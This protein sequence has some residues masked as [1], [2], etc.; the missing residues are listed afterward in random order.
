MEP[1]EVP[2]NIPAQM[3]NARQLANAEGETAHPSEPP[4]QPTEDSAL[5]R[6]WAAASKHR[7]ERGTSS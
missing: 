2:S 5:R 6:G 7:F 1:F 4:D 3:R